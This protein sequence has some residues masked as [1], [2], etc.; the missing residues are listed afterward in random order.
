MFAR[1]QVQL[2]LKLQVGPQAEGGVILGETSDLSLGGLG[3]LIRAGLPSRYKTEMVKI[4]IQRGREALL[5]VA[6]LRYQNGFH[7][8]F[9]FANVGAAQREAIRRFISGRG[10]PV[11]AV[12]G[13][14]H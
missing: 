14:T 11:A 2:P 9:E 5:V 12:S 13:Q 3:A 1:A 8:G 6:R 7:H 10:Q 4:M